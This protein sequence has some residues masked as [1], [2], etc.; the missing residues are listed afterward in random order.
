MKKAGILSAA[1]S[2]SVFLSLATLVPVQA[3]P[4][5]H[6][7]REMLASNC[8]A[9]TKNSHCHHV[10]K[11]AARRIPRSALTARGSVHWLSQI[12]DDDLFEI[13]AAPAPAAEMQVAN[14]EKLRKLV[15]TTDKF[16]PEK[17]TQ[18]NFRFLVDA[19]SEGNV[20]N[21]DDDFDILLAGMNYPK[22]RDEI[23]DLPPNGGPVEC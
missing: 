14:N 1:V 22:K 2:S 13:A 4:H 23:I 7:H 21:N 20:N 12:G 19:N 3:A 11:Q 5:G 16:L 9:T 8:H 17:L 18:N 10:T 15:A 6:G